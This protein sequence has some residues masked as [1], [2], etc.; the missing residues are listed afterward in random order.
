MIY[1]HIYTYIINIIYAPAAFPEQARQTCSPTGK[2]LSVARSCTY[3]PPVKKK[4][5]GMCCVDWDGMDIEAL[6][7]SRCVDGWLVDDVDWMGMGRLDDL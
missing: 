4:M 7:N 1:I 5:V 3:R 6:A 2:S